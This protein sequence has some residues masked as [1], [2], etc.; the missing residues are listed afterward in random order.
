MK[1][2]VT[3]GAGYIG[4]HACKAMAKA[5]HTPIVYDNLRTGHRWAVQWSDFIHGDIMDPEGLDEALR[6]LSPD[7]VMHFA[8]LAYVGESTRRPD[9]YFRTNVGGTLTLLDAMRRNNINRLVFSSSCNVYG[10]S[11]GLPLREDS[12]MSPINPYGRSKLIVE[13]MLVDL[14]RYQMLVD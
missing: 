14:C 2:L 12:V 11:D 10:A 4:S 5:G 13:Q 6:T 1:V 7:A 3:G 9:L 8:A